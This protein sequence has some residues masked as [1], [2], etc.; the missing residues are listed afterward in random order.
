MK[1]KI[2]L[3]DDDYE[4]IRLINVIFSNSYDIKTADNNTEAL[5][6]IE[7]GYKPDIILKNK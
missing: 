6:I 2:L 5:A 7:A 3:V 1:K 4:V